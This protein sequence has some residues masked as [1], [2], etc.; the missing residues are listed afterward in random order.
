M[1]ANEK[2]HTET[3]KIIN[4][5]ELVLEKIQQLLPLVKAGKKDPKGNFHEL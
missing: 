2:Q 4:V 3:R 5:I 1:M